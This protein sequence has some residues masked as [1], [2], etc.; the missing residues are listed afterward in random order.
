MNGIESDIVRL[1]QDLADR[2][3]LLG[4]M[5]TDL[6]TERGAEQLLSS[7][8]ADDADAFQEL[9]GRYELPTFPELGLCVWVREVVDS[10]LLTPHVDDTCALRSDLTPREKLSVLAIAAKHG[11]L[12]TEPFGQGSIAPGPF[13]DE[14]KARKLVHCTP[15]ANNSGPLNLLGPPQRF[16]V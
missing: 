14:L 10:V 2:L 1:H 7:L 16:C 11:I 8:V 9:I 6:A 15:T 4:A 3:R 13:L 5:F 12:L